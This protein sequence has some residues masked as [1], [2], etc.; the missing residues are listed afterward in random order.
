MRRVEPPFDPGPGTL[1]GNTGP[2]AIPRRVA[3]IGLLVEV[4][5]A[6]FAGA[7]VRCDAREVVLED[8][9]GRTRR[10]ART[11]GA[12]LVDDLRVELVPEPVASGPGS[13]GS[14]Q[15][16]STASGSIPVTDQSAQVARASRIWVEGIHDAELI[17]QVWGD[18]L[19]AAAIVVEPMHGADELA[20]AVAGFRPGPTRRL[21]VL[22]DHL[23]PDSKESR[24]AAEIDHP[25]VLV[26]GHPFVDV[27]AA[28]DPRLLDREQWP[29][30]P[31]AEPYKDGLAQRLGFTDRHEAWSALRSLVRTWR[32]LDGTLIRA[33]ESLLDHVTVEQPRS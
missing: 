20:V 18:D 30:V 2:R 3:T 26:T 4:A 1:A 32:D 33:V 22:L 27:W 31:L 15:P 5:S 28:I 7:V 11:P 24:L 29:E 8:R 6:G 10:F 16:A 19:R 21:G 23:V 17:E 9:R 14:P 25:D 12:F 13:G